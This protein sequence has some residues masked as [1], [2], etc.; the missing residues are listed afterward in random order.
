MKVSA[1]TFLFACIILIRELHN[2]GDSLGFA[3]A[4]DALFHRLERY[5]N[6]KA[7]TW[8]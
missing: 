6:D 7:R 4:A 3:V 2:E 1:F 8:T 5:V